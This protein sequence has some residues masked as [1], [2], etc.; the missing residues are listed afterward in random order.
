MAKLNPN[1]VGLGPKRLLA[2][3]ATAV[4]QGRYKCLTTVRFT[5]PAHSVRTSPS[6]PSST[7]SNRARRQQCQSH[8]Q[9]VCRQTQWPA[10]GCGPRAVA[11]QLMNPMPWNSHHRAK[12]WV[13]H[14]RPPLGVTGDTV[15]TSNDTSPLLQNSHRRDWLW[16]ISTGFVRVI[17]RP[18]PY[19][20]QRWGHLHCTRPRYPEVINSDHNRFSENCTPGAYQRVKDLHHNV[21]TKRFCLAKIV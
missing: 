18:T 10:N 12:R 15:L 11:A 1:G 5:L 6:V 20:Q 3:I 16:T 14:R 9:G 8:P 2:A 4:E 13:R 21:N 17:T 19:R 7:M